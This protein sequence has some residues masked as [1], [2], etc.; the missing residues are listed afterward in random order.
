MGDD[1]ESEESEESE[2]AVDHDSEESD[3]GPPAKIRRMNKPGL[4]S[5]EKAMNMGITSNTFRRMV[6][7]AI[8]ILVFNML[9]LVNS[10]LGA[11]VRSQWVT[12]CP[13]VYKMTS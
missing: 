6:R 3:D 9:F 10:E 11:P 2:E 1:A 5:A 7:G 4:S 12:E 8:P 13:V